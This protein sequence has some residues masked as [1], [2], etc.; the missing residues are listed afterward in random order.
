MYLIHINFIAISLNKINLTDINLKDINMK[1]NFK[2]LKFK[3][4]DCRTPV[5]HKIHFSTGFLLDQ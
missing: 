5:Y 1:F 3:N 2:I 4:L